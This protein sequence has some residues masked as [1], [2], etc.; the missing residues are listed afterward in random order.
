MEEEQS[1]ERSNTAPGDTAHSAE[2]TLPTGPCEEGEADIDEEDVNSD[3][4][5][6]MQGEM[7]VAQPAGAI[8]G[9]QNGPI[10]DDAADSV[11]EDIGEHKTRFPLLKVAMKLRAKRNL[12]SKVPAVRKVAG[13]LHRRLFEVPDTTLS[14]ATKKQASKV[15]TR[16]R[17]A[18]LKWA[19]R[20]L[21]KRPP[22]MAIA[23]MAAGPPEEDVVAMMQRPGQP[24]TQIH[25]P[26][27][28]SQD[29][30]NERYF[31]QK[32]QKELES[33][34]LKHKIG[35]HVAQLLY[36]I[37]KMKI[38]GVV[39]SD[40]AAASEALLF[41][42]GNEDAEETSCRADEW[43]GTWNQRLRAFLGAGPDMNLDSPWQPDPDRLSESESAMLAA[44]H[45]EDRQMSLA[46]QA[47]RDD[48]AAM[49]SE[50]AAQ[51]LASLAPVEPHG[52]GVGELSLGEVMMG[53]A[54][55]SEGAGSV[56][57]ILS[58]SAV[59]IAEGTLLN[60]RVL[61]PKRRRV[62]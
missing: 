31:F 4:T 13:I 10:P 2:A 8:D 23:D 6:L 55:A 35:A 27:G 20:L 42:Y 51:P 34:K 38:E 30:E 45:E 50:L 62:E 41:A 11:F 19:R 21:V 12:G 53:S 58:A 60:M 26:R 40:R 52:A 39:A 14:P 16:V 37:R 43:A 15:W 36:Y 46:A 32:L 9:V 57:Q 18:C 48:D 59:E 22:A 24:G 3:D 49:A 25:W 28:D 56:P 54:S 7:V 5:N 29:A 47:Q 44:L 33:T 17:R 61:L 1:Q